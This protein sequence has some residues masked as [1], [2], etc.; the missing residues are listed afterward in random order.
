MLSGSLEHPGHLVVTHRQDKLNLL[1]LFTCS[2]APIPLSIQH[3]EA[4]SQG[5]GHTQSFLDYSLP[6]NRVRHTGRSFR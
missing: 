4:V 5:S 2:S 1:A 6:G 3:H